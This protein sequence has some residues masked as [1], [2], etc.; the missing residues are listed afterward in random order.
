MRGLT[1]YCSNCGTKLADNVRFC[2]KC[3]VRVD[4]NE[5]NTQS[6]T[7]TQGA[8][9]ESY[10][11]RTMSGENLK[12]AISILYDMEQ[13]VYAT[14]RMIEN[15]DQRISKLGL[16]YR[17]DVPVKEKVNIQNCTEG[18]HKKWW[19]IGTIAG[20]LLGGF[21]GIGFID[22]I[23]GLFTGGI[24]GGFVGFVI[25]LFIAEGISSSKI[26]KAQKEADERYNVVYKNYQL[27]C[28]KQELRIEQE[29]KE[30]ESLQNV[31]KQLLSKKDT[32][33][34]QLK[35]FYDMVGIDRDYR[36]LVPIGYMK[37]YLRLNI[38][39]Q[40]HGPTGLN[41][42]IRKE[43]R[44]D[45]LRM[46]M[47]EISDKLSTLLEIN[48]A[49]FYELVT[50]TDKCDQIIQV[51]GQTVHLMAQNNQ[52]LQDL[53]DTQ[54]MNAYYNARI[55]AEEEYRNRMDTICGRWS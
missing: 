15:I 4:D 46:T 21:I 41:F 42:Y 14:S 54:I 2:T 22:L 6:I 37:D 51:V 53:K 50:L 10:D 19:C 25:G 7:N 17:I 24:L 5:I 12:E 31:K 52:V 44:E 8:S 30:I 49:V 38:S 18:V 48:K 11:D 33:C 23:G 20:M 45:M 26:S 27:S 32:T 34:K 9:P 28:Q 3:G 16:R 35:L 36:N 47:E 39:T 43:L 55:A 40:L 29:M 1:M 13:D